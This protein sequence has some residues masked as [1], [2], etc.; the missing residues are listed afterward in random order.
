MINAQYK[1]ILV[2][3]HCKKKIYSQVGVNDVSYMTTFGRWP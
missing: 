3:Y 2:Y 1:A